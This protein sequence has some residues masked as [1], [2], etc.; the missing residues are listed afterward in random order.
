LK[1]ASA[2]EVS[3]ELNF[4]DPAHFSKFFKAQKANA[5]HF[6]DFYKSASKQA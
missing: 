5:P 4:A 2:K 1:L 6:F 3:Y